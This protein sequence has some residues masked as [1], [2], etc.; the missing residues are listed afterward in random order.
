MESVRIT[1]AGHVQGVGFRPFV[2]RLASRHGVVGQV[3]NRL[4]EVDIIASGSAD[5]LRQFESEL[6]AKAPPLSRPVITGVERVEARHDADFVIAASSSDADARIFV[7]PDYFMCDD[8][9][10]ELQD[11]EDRRYRY[12]FINCTQCGPRYTLIDSLPYD[13]HNTSMRSFPLCADCE[14]EYLDPANRRFHAEPVACPACGPQVSYDVPGTAGTLCADAALDATI[15][16]LRDGRIV[17]VKG[18]GGYHL[19]CDASS[20]EAVAEL[21]RRKQR[22]DKPLAVMFPIAGNGGLDIVRHH[23]MLSDAE[24][25]LLASPAR[26]IVL[27]TKRASSTLADN[28]APALREIGA[29]LPYSPL[30]QL[31]LE[32]FA[33]PLVA[34]SGNISGE[35]VLTENDE[36]AH[37]LDAVADAFLHHD[38][39]IVRPADDPVY[40]RIGNRMRPLRLGRGCAPLEMTLPWR[41]PVPVLAAGGHMKGALALSWDDR[42]VVSPHIGEMDS[43]RSLAVFEQVAADLQALYGVEA[44]MVACDA[45]SGYTTHQ[46]ARH[47]ALPV[48]TVWHHEAHATAVA[49]EFSRPGQW[50]MFAWDGVGLGDDGTLWGGEALLGSAGDWRRVC[51]LRPFRLPGGERAGREPWRSAAAL[52]W[53]CGRQWPECP[54][55]RGLAEFAWQRQLNSPLT[56]AAGRLFDAAAA[57]IC[58]QTHTSF[59]AQGPMQLESLARGSRHPA[60]LSLTRGRNGI[61]TSDWEPLLEIIADQERS[62]E[63]RSEIFHASLAQLIVQQACRVRY[64]NDIE[65]V[66]LCGGV[67]QN[68]LLTELA[69]EG[70]ARRGFDVFLPEQLPCN[71]AALCY[72]QAAQ[73]AARSHRART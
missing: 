54:D 29:F 17:A 18:I 8:C 55:E 63:E 64:E 45:H 21:R 9:R 43:P 11:P 15:D 10:G 65:Q 12:P 37:R 19:M 7:P 73:L 4:G 14:R 52:L 68:R 33:G 69:I 66:G 71:D 16:A 49:A 23:A 51:S 39:P 32:A 61:L 56:S 34:T 35:P 2:Y 13:R 31:L 20:V 36:A 1:L 59:E 70:L 72:G 25:K 40:R 41:Q 47:Q 48:E 42:V 50:L 53:E 57:L 60:Y 58:G 27:V 46:W 62:P 24:S 26:P 5:V 67:F 28:V 38:R 30:H 44:E 3:R 6:V 22:P